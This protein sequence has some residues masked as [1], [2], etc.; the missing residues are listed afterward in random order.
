MTFVRNPLISAS[1]GIPATLADV[2]RQVKEAFSL[3]GNKT[4]IQIGRAFREQF[5]V[6]SDPKVVFVPESMG[7]KLDGPIMTGN[8]AS[9]W[10]SCDVYVR[11]RG[12]KDPIEQFSLA[13]DLLDLVVG[14]V[15]V[16][17][18]GRLAFGR[19]S[20]DTPL[21][22]DPSG[23]GLGFSFT[24]RRDILHSTA[25][26]MLPPADAITDD[27][28]AHPPPGIPASGVEID[29]IAI[30]QLRIDEALTGEDDSPLLGADN[31]S[32]ANQSM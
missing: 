26:W 12:S 19:V 6:G 23:S 8:A 10:H 31:G 15:A 11:A 16:A 7:G 17:G 2:I 13:Y 32:L 5:G 25:R 24:Y 28:S 1:E 14:C 29:A 21:K 20:D 22:N 27:A 9:Y 18:T 30:P 4:P 3:M